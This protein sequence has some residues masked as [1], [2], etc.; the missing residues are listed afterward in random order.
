MLRLGHGGS[1]LAVV[2]ASLLAAG[3]LAAPTGSEGGA[4][5]GAV[6]VNG[7]GA[8]AT[9]PGARS[10]LTPSAKGAKGGTRCPSHGQVTDHGGPVQTDPTVYVD[11]WG[12]TS[13]PGERPYLISFLSSIGGSLWLSTVRQYCASDDPRLAGQWSDTSRRPPARPTNADIQDE[14]TVAAAYFGIK[15][16]PAHD[17]QNVQIIVALPT[18]T[19]LPPTDSEDCAYH[20][21]L[22]PPAGSTTGPRVVVTALPY[23]PDPAYGAQCGAF[24]VN[25]GAHG[26]LDGVSIAEGHEL[27]ESITDPEGNAWHDNAHPANEI[28]DKCEDDADYD[29][30]AGGHTFAVQ[31]LWSNAAGGCVVVGAPAGAPIDVRAIG[32][33]AHID[34]SWSA[35]DNDGGTP[36]TGWLVTA[37]PG[38]TTCTESVHTTC[39]LPKL[40]NATTYSVSVRA[41]N[42]VGLGRASPGV[43]ATPSSAQNCSFFGPYADLQGCNFSGADLVG[44]PLSGADLAGADLAGADLSDADLA[45][46]DLAGADIGGGTLAGTDLFGSDLS[47]SSLTGADLQDCDLSGVNLSGADVSGTNLGAVSSSGVTGTPIALPAHWSLVDGYLIGPGADLDEAE[48]SFADLSDTDLSGADLAYANLISANVSNADLAKADLYGANVSD[49]DLKGADVSDADL[50]T[51]NPFALLCPDG[52]FSNDDGGRCDSS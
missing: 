8:P 34:V 33:D 51:A 13:D 30:Q 1:V 27:A 45:G 43:P 26:A 36:I 16:T 7:G 38:S 24:A 35:P 49:A 50:A 39:V 23:L 48:L 22:R 20:E 15:T 42:A 2:T 4:V 40:A 9:G 5:A 28:A 29:I 21:Q 46:A 25:E 3:L 10:S 44:L 14:G 52:T 37:T 32:V 6:V 12:W 19:S 31:Q 41:S 18:R 11:F 47:A 17:D